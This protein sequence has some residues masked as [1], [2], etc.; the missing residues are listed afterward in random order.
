[1]KSLLMLLVGAGA[2]GCNRPT[3]E[4]AAIRRVLER[5][6]ATWR[7]GDVPG[8]AACWHLQPYS[9][10]LISTPEGQVLDVPPA[11]IVA[12]SPAMG[13]GGHA[14]NTHYKMSIHG[15]TAWVSHDE[16][17]TAKDGHQTFSHE[18][19]LL[20]KIDNQWKLVGQSIHLY[21]P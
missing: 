12:P 15:G 8:H 4:A 17:S 19:R 1:M 13:Q 11:R 9:R 14:V 18:I 20:E 21:K 7:A 2:V 10:I 3:D 16:T 5:E 6:S